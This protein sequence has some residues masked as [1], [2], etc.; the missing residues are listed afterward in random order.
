MSSIH[1]VTVTAASIA[2]IF[3]IT[4]TM[5]FSEESHIEENANHQGHYS[6]P[7]L[8]KGNSE[9][10]VPKIIGIDRHSTDSSEPGDALLYSQWKTQ[11]PMQFHDTD[12]TG[13]LRVDE[14]GN[15]IADDQARQVFDYFL[16]AQDD[17]DLNQIKSWVHA[18][19]NEHLAPPADQQAI[20]V[21]QNYIRYKTELNEL[22]VDEEIWGRLYDPSQAV[23][24]S[25]LKSLSEVFRDRQG[26]QAQLF[27]QETQNSLFGEDNQYDNY[28]LQ[29]LEIT[30]SG[31]SQASITEQLAQLDKQQSPETIDNRAASQVAI[32]HKDLNETLN[33]ADSGYKYQ[34]YSQTYGDEA[35]NRLMAL[36]EKR[37]VFSEKRN[38]Y[39]AYKSTLNHGESPEALEDYM[40]HELA[41]TEGEMKRMQMLD[42][43]DTAN[44]N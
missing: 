26:L 20:S 13:E 22:S 12:V 11:L 19:I 17:V 35:A 24:Q 1:K 10:S 7:A 44:I 16:T 14:Q 4:A 33:S 43:M 32:H 39:L 23:T 15:F 27:D 37:Q 28:M 30:L 8:T 21:L 2:I 40:K 18:Y 6:A 29:R 25:D 34:V 41:L 38:R 3:G 5:W 42:K 31:E 9:A 36:E